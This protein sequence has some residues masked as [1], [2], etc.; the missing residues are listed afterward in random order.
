LVNTLNTLPF[1]VLSQ[2]VIEST[3]KLTQEA[4]P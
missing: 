2:S 4:T 1:L 3:V